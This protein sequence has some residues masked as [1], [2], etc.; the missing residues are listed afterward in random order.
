MDA[1]HIVVGALTA[2]TVGLLVWIESHGNTFI[3]GGPNGSR[4][5]DSR[6]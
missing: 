3:A 1:S 4:G 6:H 5:P 2:V